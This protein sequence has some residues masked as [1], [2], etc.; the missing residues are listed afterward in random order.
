MSLSLSLGS[1]LAEVVISSILRL[2][3][4]SSQTIELIATC[5]Q[6]LM[7]KFIFKT[8][9]FCFVLYNGQLKNAKVL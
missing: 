6:T 1:I 7:L 4:S 8:F 2:M 9:S 5:K 3:R